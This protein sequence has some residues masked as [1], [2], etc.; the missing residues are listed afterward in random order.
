MDM[1]KSPIAVQ[2]AT[3]A[4]EIAVLLFPNF[5]NHCLAN[6]V[7]PLRAANTLAHRPLYRWQYIG[8]TG[9]TL[10]SSS[11]LP[12][13]PE[14][15]IARHAGADYLFVLPSYDTEAHATPATLRALRSAHKR[16]D[17]M[18]GLDMGS[19]LLAAAG[20]LDG[21]RA[22]LPWDE[23]D[24]FAERF[25]EVDV[26]PERIVDDGDILSCGGGATAFEL[27][28]KQI[29][30]HH[31]AILRLEVAALFMHGE[32]PASA[33]LSPLSDDH[34]VDSAVALMRRHVEAPLPLAAIARRL[35]VTP[36]SLERRFRRVLGITPGATYRSLRLGSAK[37]LVEQTTLSLGEIATRCGYEDASA[38]TRAFRIAFGT[39]PRDVRR[40]F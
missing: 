14:D 38:F 40:R 11:G 20:L 31:G 30:R 21:R 23:L 26:S 17:T 3:P 24:R 32:R 27:I 28:L 4:Q 5:S 6:A 37:R 2:E 12:V 9:E 1:Q 25:P 18:V 22:T 8:I 15:T 29:G 35:K 19:W 36:R 13:T 33:T 34:L 39:S 16:F 10:V 7:E